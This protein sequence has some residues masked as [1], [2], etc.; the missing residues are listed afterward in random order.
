MSFLQ[1]TGDFQVNHVNFQGCIRSNRSAKHHFPRSSQLVPVVALDEGVPRVVSGCNW[2]EIDIFGA[3]FEW[4]N[5]KVE[6][7]IS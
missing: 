3:K 5:V 4:R 7:K 1:K 6:N 2:E